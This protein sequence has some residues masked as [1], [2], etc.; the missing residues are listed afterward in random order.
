MRQASCSFQA[1]Q[2]G[3]LG[4]L[5]C[6]LAGGG[7]QQARGAAACSLCSCIRAGVAA[8]AAA[9]AG[10]KA[11]SAPSKRPSHRAPGPTAMAGAC[12]TRAWHGSGATGQTP[13]SKRMEWDGSVAGHCSEITHS[14]ALFSLKWA[15]ES[16]AEDHVAVYAV[17]CCRSYL[18]TMNSYE[19]SD[20]RYLAS[21]NLTAGKQWSTIKVQTPGMAACLNLNKRDSILHHAA[22]SFHNPNACF[23]PA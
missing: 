15:A 2:S 5:Q 7:D 12:G 1:A 21:P 20:F 10:I 23:K 6:L 3:A 13:R 14:L 4:M 11:S 22:D 9:G 8:A 18:L 17:T 19:V 16:D